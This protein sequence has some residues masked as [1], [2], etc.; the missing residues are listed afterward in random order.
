MKY[1]DLRRA[2]LVLYTA[3]FGLAGHLG[4]QEKIPLIQKS[5]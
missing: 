2:E 4:S 5:R 1:V 3:H